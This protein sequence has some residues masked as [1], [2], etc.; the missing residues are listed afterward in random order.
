[1]LSPLSIVINERKGQFLMKS[2]PRMTDLA[3]KAS[4][5]RF[6]QSMKHFSPILISDA[7]KIARFSRFE[8]PLNACAQINQC[9][10]MALKIT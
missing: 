8:H 7:L 1:M 9:N 6:S 10:L 4:D 2:L 3:I 5:L